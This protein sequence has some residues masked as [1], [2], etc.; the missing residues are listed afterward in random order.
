MCLVFL[1][2]EV[3]LPIAYRTN[4][5]LEL[6]ITMLCSYAYGSISLEAVH[7]Y[8]ALWEGSGTDI[9]LFFLKS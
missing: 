2:L 7:A 1:V 3:T 5:R 8:S 9:W 6:T 4:Y